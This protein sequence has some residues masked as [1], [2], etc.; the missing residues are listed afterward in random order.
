MGVDLCRLCP[1][2][3]QN[4]VVRFLKFLAHCKNQSPTT[5]RENFASSSRSQLKKSA[6]KLG[7]FLGGIFTLL[8][9]LQ[10]ANGKVTPEH[11]LNGTR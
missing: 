11:S 1:H 9:V 7:T 2:F 3:S 5:D 10:W 4:L 8:T 6:I